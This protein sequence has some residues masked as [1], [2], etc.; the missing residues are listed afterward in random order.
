MTDRLDEGYSPM[1]IFDMLLHPSQGEIPKLYKSMEQLGKQMNQLQGDIKKYNGLYV[2]VTE[3]N[4]KFD[5]Q[6]ARCNEV[7]NMKATA[8][9]V[10]VATG[11]LK[12]LLIQQG[13]EEERYRFERAIKLI[14]AGVLILT[15]ATGLITWFFNLW[16]F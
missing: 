1:Q 8:E 12:R 4:T 15:T 5:K 7:Q 9:A 10:D 3:M 11:D 13:M 16:G 14:G 2:K 6:I